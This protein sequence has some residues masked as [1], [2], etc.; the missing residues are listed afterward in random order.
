MY[1]IIEELRDISQMLDKPCGCCTEE[2]ICLSDAEDIIKKLAAKWTQEENAI[3]E[4][5]WYSRSNEAR[6]TASNHIQNLI[7]DPK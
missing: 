2:Y 4:L 7:G 1:P 5:G 3:E 6:K